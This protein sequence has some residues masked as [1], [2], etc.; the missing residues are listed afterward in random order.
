MLVYACLY[1]R[2]QHDSFSPQH[3]KPFGTVQ[4]P[5]DNVW[6]I[7]PGGRS[8]QWAEEAKIKWRALLLL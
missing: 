8:D 6:L 7:E 4:H 5:A 1:L 2:L 3:F